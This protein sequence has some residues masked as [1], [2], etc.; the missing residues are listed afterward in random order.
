MMLVHVLSGEI[1]LVMIPFT[2]LVHCVL[3]PFDWYSSGLFWQLRPGA[4]EDVAR[5]LHGEEPGI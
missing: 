3:I 2:K 5:E 1:V 4:G